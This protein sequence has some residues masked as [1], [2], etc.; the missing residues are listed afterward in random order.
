MFVWFVAVLGVCLL[1]ATHSL[2]TETVSER[3]SGAV[4]VL[5]ADNFTSFVDEQRV[6]LV[7]FMAPW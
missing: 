1:S 6:V 4:A 3:V 2:A 7:Q 5:T